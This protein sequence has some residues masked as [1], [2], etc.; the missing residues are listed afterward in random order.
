MSTLFKRYNYIFGRYTKTRQK[1]TRE[2]FNRLQAHNLKLQLTKCKFLHKKVIHL[3][4]KIF[5]LGVQPNEQQIISVRNFS[6]PENVKEFKFFLELTGYYR[7]FIPDYSKIAKLIT[8]L[9][10][11]ILNF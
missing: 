8:N 9:L 4:Y 10:I 1:I 2:I 11:K 5:E 6:I 7:N 3:G